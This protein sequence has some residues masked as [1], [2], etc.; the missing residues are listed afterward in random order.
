L[1]DGA[2][3]RVVITSRLSRLWPQWGDDIRAEAARIG[4][5]VQCVL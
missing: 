3:G 1:P 2:F 5:S 4:A